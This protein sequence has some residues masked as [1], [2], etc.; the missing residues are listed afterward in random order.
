MFTVAA[1]SDVASTMV[2]TWF[3]DGVD[4]ATT[5]TDFTLSADG[6]TLTLNDVASV[7]NGIEYSVEVTTMKGICAAETSSA[8]LTVEGPIMIDTQPVDDVVCAGNVAEF[9]VEASIP[10]N[11]GTL[12]YLWQ[13]SELGDFSDAVSVGTG[14]VY[15]NGNTQSSQN[16]NFYRVI[17]S[18][19]LCE[20]TSD[21]AQLTV[22]GPLEITDPIDDVVI[23]DDGSGAVMHTFTVGATA[24]ESTLQYVWQVDSGTGFV[25]I[26]GETASTLT[27]TVDAMDDGNVYKAIVSTD[28]GTCAPLETVATLSVEGPITITNQP[29]NITSCEGLTAIFTVDA[30]GNNTD[31]IYA[32]EESVDN[33]ATWVFVGNASTYVKSGLTLNDHNNQYRV[34]V[35]TPGCPA[36]ISDVA[37]LSVIGV[38]FINED[39][40]DQAIE[41]DSD[42]TIT[43]DIT[44]MDQGITTS[45]YTFQWQENDGTGWV[46]IADG[47]VYSGAT[48]EVL[49]LT[50]VPYS[51]R[52]NRYRIRISTGICNLTAISS[53]MTLMVDFDCDGDGLLNFQSVD[54]DNDGIVDLV[55][56]GGFDV[57]GDEDDD[58]RR[59]FEDPDYSQFVDGDGNGVSDQFDVDGDG[60]INQC[61]ID[62]DGN[63]VMDADEAGGQLGNPVDTDNDG[64]DDYL[65]LDND[66]NG[67]LDTDEIGDP[68]NPT[69]TDADGIP[70][71]NDFDNDGDGISDVYEIGLDPTNPL[72]TDGDG[73]ED[74]NDTDSDNDGLSD[75]YEAIDGDEPVDTDN[76]GLEDYRDTDSD[77]NGIDDT[78]ES[79]GDETSAIDT[80][81]D[82]IPDHIDF[83]NDNDSLDDEF[84]LE[85]VIYDGTEFIPN[86]DNTIGTPVFV[87]SDG[88]GIANY[89]DDDDDGVPTIIEDGNENGFLLDDIFDDC[90]RDLVFDYLDTD[91]CDDLVFPNGFTPNGDGIHEVF[92]VPF[93]YAYPNFEM[94][95]LDRHGN[96]VYEFSD[97]GDVATEPAWWNGTDKNEGGEVMPSATYFYRVKFNREQ[98]PVKT[99]WVF[100]RS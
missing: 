14:P 8:I 52:D 84:E 1:S 59:N 76:D 75:A 6:T 55:E 94:Q 16:G 90:D 64:I 28:V 45:P 88:D 51:F 99:G 61:D 54:D 67:I 19:N 79:G 71:Y 47:G 12:S 25:D 66:N 4:I 58:D 56:N 5:A 60:L 68:T 11:G 50:M 100:L 48:T 18:T 2:Y 29:V 95:I 13:E 27:L 7:D 3:R 41:V 78:S 24:G 86:P 10:A 32:W 87:D 43:A 85:L 17:I 30:N 33:G 69:D 80:D 9:R 37:T 26:A 23:C 42:T 39:P 22:D 49:Q 91:L 15:I 73:T 34:L 98:R 20:V 72:D 46:D 36:E 96:L 53:P 21:A 38:P 81:R 40:E 97:D 65:D 93:L 44:L 63:G 82:G 74:Y 83:D 89:L 77:D 62:A 31:L 35:S 57:Y 70:D 92:V